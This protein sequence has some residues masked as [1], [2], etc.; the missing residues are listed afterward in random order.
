MGVR[1][2]GVVHAVLKYGPAGPIKYAVPRHKE[3]N[4]WRNVAVLGCADINT[5]DNSKKVS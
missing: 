5:W 4:T 1:G 3:R 2:G